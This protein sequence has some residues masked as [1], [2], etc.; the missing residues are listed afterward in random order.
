MSPCPNLDEVLRYMG[1]DR[2]DPQLVETAE[3]SVAV[4][5]KAIAP[6][7]IYRKFDILREPAGIR[8]AGSDVI[9]IGQDIA[10]HLKGCQACYLL[11]GTL[12]ASADRT[13]KLGSLKSMLE[14]LALNSAATEL[15]ENLM[16]SAQAEI[17]QK[18]AENGGYLTSRFSPGY[19]DLPISLQKELLFLCDAP[20]K[21]GLSVTENNILTPKK[22]VT[23][24]LGVS[25]HPT[26]GK[27]K[28]CAFCN[29]RER[30]TFR[31]A[32]TT[33]GH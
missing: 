21:I 1:A 29:M 8:L 5:S 15:T 27:I 11:A 16:D 24:I 9:L 6:K 23:A 25:D 19:G 17:G 22:S 12:G 20:R 2:S 4:L 32:G 14:G 10:L 18:E 31:K 26:L 28:G 7:Y 30:C 13:I 33:C 3:R